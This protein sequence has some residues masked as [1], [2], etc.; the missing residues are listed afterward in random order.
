MYVDAMKGI[1]FALC[2]SIIQCAISGTRDHVTRDLM[3]FQCFVLICTVSSMFSLL[4]LAL[5]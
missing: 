1:G 3:C 2:A 4:H 5:L